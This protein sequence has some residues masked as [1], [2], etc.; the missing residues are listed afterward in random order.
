MQN[1]SLN[2]K[3]LRGR[4]FTSRAQISVASVCSSNIFKMGALYNVW[5]QHTSVLGKTPDHFN[6]PYN[7]KVL[8]RANIS[9]DSLC[10]EDGPGVYRTL[11]SSAKS[12]SPTAD[13]PQ[14]FP[15][16]LLQRRT[17]YWATPYYLHNPRLVFCDK[18]AFPS[19][20]EEST[21]LWMCREPGGAWV[22]NPPWIPL[23][24]ICSFFICDIDDIFCFPNFGILFTKE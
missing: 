11:V 12:Q 16:S 1:C 3:V 23:I 14:P 19:I 22:Q 7:G 15:D 18:S 20:W 2:V 5:Q 6:H 24:H 10:R 8:T 17:P 4:V 21:C 9:K 13:S